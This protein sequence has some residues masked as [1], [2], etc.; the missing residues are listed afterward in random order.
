MGKNIRQKNSK[1]K[2]TLKDTYTDSDLKDLKNLIIKE[3]Q[4]IL[5][6]SQVWQQGNV[7]Q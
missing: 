1:I 3:K 4:N 7:H 5:N 6:Q 2:S